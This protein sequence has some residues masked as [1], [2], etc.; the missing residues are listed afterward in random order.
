MDVDRHVREFD[1]VGYTLVEQVV[2]D[3]DRHAL[4][5]ATATALERDWERCRDLPGKQRFIVLDL[6]HHDR[7]FR[8]FL[9]NPAINALFDRLIGQQWILYSF[10]STVLHPNERPY[11]CE[12][13]TDT[14]RFT[15]GYVTSALAT[16][17]LDD[18]T[19]QNGATWFLPGS[20][21][22]EARPTDEEF[23]AGAVQAVRRAGDAVVFHPRVW[24]AGGSNRTTETRFGL[25]V[26]GCRP[27]MKQR[28]D[29]P[30]MLG[31]RELAELGSVG[32]RIL[33]YDARVP[34][35]LEEFYRVPEER[36]Y[37]AGQA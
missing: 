2:T 30:R 35:S 19:S 29:F 6:V 18:F 15:D 11:T 16:L 20:H 25:T 14:S 24:H 10:T 7:L 12:I 23:W 26:Y 33:G 28:F 31:V 22:V 36:L 37:K 8:Q 34:A 21:R 9:E 32:R 1:E 27:W 4:R 17:A 5:C 3:E 13:H